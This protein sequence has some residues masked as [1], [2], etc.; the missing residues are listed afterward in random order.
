VSRENLELLQRKP[1]LSEK[2][3]DHRVCGVPLKTLVNWECQNF[4]RQEDIG[5]AVEIVVKP[6]SPAAP[7]EVTS[8]R[9]KGAKSITIA[10]IA[11][12]QTACQQK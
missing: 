4:E 2:I 1:H 11:Q 6:Q 3:C 7:L 12:Y 5:R 8:L 9:N 10:S